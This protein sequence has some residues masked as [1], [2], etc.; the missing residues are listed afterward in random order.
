[1]AITEYY[2]NGEKFMTTIDF[3][4]PLSAIEGLER[5]TPEARELFV[6]ASSIEVRGFHE[7]LGF[8]GRRIVWSACARWDEETEKWKIENLGN[9]KMVPVWPEEA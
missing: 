6:G 3:R 2:E 8:N 5:M 4:V 9:G 7:L 1:M